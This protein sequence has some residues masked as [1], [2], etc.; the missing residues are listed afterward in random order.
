MRVDYAGSFMAIVFS[1]LLLL[2]LTWG[3]VTHPWTSAAVLVPLV[4]SGVMFVLFL[5]WEA[6][7]ATLPIVPMRVLV[8]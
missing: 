5:V 4:L 2:G 7:F 6:K 8:V 1:V 3:G